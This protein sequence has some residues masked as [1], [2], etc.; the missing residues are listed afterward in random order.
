ML[1]LPCRFDLQEKTSELCQNTKR[2]LLDIQ[3]RSDVKDSG[4]QVSLVNTDL[5]A[6]TYLNSKSSN[7]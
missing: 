2:N 7:F 4:E 6:I 1:D 3:T 5:V